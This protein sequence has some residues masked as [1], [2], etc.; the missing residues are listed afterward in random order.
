MKFIPITDGYLNPHQVI[1]VSV[2]SQR[3]TQ[4]YYDEDPKTYM[5][6]TIKALVR[7]ESFVTLDYLVDKDGTVDIQAVVDRWLTKIAEAM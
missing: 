6:Y 4:H 5:Q 1:T 2:D 3:W 7:G